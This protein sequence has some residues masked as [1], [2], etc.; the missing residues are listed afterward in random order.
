MK[1]NRAAV[2]AARSGVPVAAGYF[3]ELAQP[4]PP[5]LDAGTS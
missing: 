5:K 3:R 1:R 2:L 4:P